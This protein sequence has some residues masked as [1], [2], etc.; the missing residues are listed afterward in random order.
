MCGHDA[1]LPI[2]DTKVF[3]MTQIELPLEKVQTAKSWFSQ[4][5]E[6]F[7]IKED[8]GWPNKFGL[9]LRKWLEQKKERE[10]RVLS[11]FTG[12]GGLDIGFHDTGFKIIEC[13]EIEKEFTKTLIKNKEKGVCLEEANIVCCDIKDYNPE[14][15]NIDFIIGGPP[16]QT[17][18]A[19]GARA[20]GVNG[21]DDSRGNLFLEYARIV[22]QLSPKGFLFENVYRLLGAQGGKSWAT[23]KETFNSLGYKLFWRILDTSDYG[24]PQFRERLII[25]GLRDGNFKFPYPTH[26]PDS[27]D[28]R[29]YYTSGCAVA[30]I[31]TS[32]CKVGIGGR[33]GHL[34][35][36]I[37]P[38]LNY[39][40]YTEKLG[41][42]QPKFSW[43]SKFSDYLYKADPDRPVRTIKAQG[44]QYTGPFSWENRH[45]TI[46]ELKRLQT[47]PDDYIIL[48]NRQK[49]INQLGNSVP[50]QL[51]RIL[52]LSILDQ[53]FSI[54]LPFQIDYLPDSYKLGF[55]QR[56]ARLTK[57]YQ[58]KASEAIS[59]LKLNQVNQKEI[60]YPNEG[61]HYFSI[62]NDLKLS[63][64]SV[65]NRKIFN[66]QYQVSPNLW[67]IKINELGYQGKGYQISIHLD[68]SISNSLSANQIIIDVLS[69]RK[70]SILATWKYLEYLVSSLSPKDDLVQL[71]GYYQYK[72]KY[73][74]LVEL[75]DENIQ[76]N[77]F[78]KIWS[79][80]S[81]GLG[82]GTIMSASTYEELFEQPWS[83]IYEIFINIKELGYEIRSHKSNKQIKAGYFL[84]PYPFPSLNERSLQRMTNL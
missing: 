47:F 66:G 27:Q 44:G 24:V 53:V 50:P 16:C 39:S 72:R 29:P 58:K 9:S 74:I 10:I 64:E 21:T 4:Y 38:G 78:W 31:D 71:F 19:A 79:K 12:G 63:F 17:F 3:M 41:H 35:N 20:A 49:I 61:E 33:H 51:S 81:R 45:F 65:S 82:V 26:G 56:K 1:T 70:D 57:L 32:G 5:L 15:T 73:E 52:A 25:V 76:Q 68:D 18:S 67:K 77:N 8:S 40:F 34:L 22:K 30:D 14:L 11:L 28:N 13:N 69:E 46:E 60:S 75:I 48:G 43:R 84:V 42:P 23:I 7:K 83:N 62:L 37:P 54:K 36:D 6:F 80:I 2:T 59:E 55:R